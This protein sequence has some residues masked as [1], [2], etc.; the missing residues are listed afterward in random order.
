[1]GARDRIRHLGAAGDVG[2]HQPGA[3]GGKRV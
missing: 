2:D 3:F 1:V